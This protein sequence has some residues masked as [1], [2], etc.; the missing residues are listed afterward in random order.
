MGK[1]DDKDNKTALDLINLIKDLVTDELNKR[2]NTCVCQVVACNEDGTYN[3]FVVPD[4]RTVITN[5]KSMS[6]EVIK[7]GDYVYVYKIQNKLN[8][9]IILARAGTNA[10]DIRFV[11]VENFNSTI[12][13]RSSGG[14]GGKVD[15][16]LVNN[17]SVVG[18]DKVAR[19]DLT[20]Y[21]LKSEL[22]DVA[23]S[24][25]YD[26]LANK[27]YIPTKTSDLINDS[28]YITSSALTNYVTTDTPQT[29]TANKTFT[30]TTHFG[31]G[32][33]ITIDSSG[34]SIYTPAA[35][36]L[37]GAP[38]NL[39]SSSIIMGSASSFKTNRSDSYGLIIP[40]TTSWTSNKTIATTT[41]MNIF[42]F[43]SASLF[44]FFSSF[45][46]SIS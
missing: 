40:T 44:C 13:S 18:E 2:D 15:D 12:T 20:S 46:L 25:D 17:T 11:T 41:P 19:I 10:A 30:G 14:E 23:L 45:S 35:L 26:D 36:N 28:G 32:N 29:V 5:V 42:F 33:P 1:R 31:S 37:Y 21:V 8:N 38:I 34:I 3:I 7:V 39:S 24:G 6:L 22:A 4:T 9:A 43:L 16:V 27:P